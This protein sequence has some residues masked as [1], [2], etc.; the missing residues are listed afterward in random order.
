MIDKTLIG[1]SILSGSSS[2]LVGAGVILDG[3]AAFEGNTTES[4]GFLSFSS[5]LT[6]IELTG[7][8]SYDTAQAVSYIESLDEREVNDLLAQID[9]NLNIQIDDKAVVKTRR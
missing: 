7:T 2:A 1:S 9:A 3:E 6:A 4:V 5:A 8:Q